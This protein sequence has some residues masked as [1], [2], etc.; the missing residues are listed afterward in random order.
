MA[1]TIL[2]VRLEVLM[3]VRIIMTV[4]WDVVHYILKTAGTSEMLVLIRET[5]WRHILEDCNIE[6]LCMFAV[7]TLLYGFTKYVP[8]VWFILF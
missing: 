3:A 6:Q 4:F 1:I 5:N 8:R 2:Y 7:S